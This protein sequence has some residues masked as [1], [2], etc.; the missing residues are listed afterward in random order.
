MPTVWDV[1]CMTIH[2]ACHTIAKKIKT[3]FKK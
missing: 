2:Y 1:V 3:L